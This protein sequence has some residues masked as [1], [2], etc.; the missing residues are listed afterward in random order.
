MV[1]VVVVFGYVG[2][3]FVLVCLILYW[4]VDVL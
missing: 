1:G 3:W 4:F 2:G